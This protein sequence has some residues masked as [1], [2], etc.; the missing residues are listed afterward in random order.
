LETSDH[1]GIFEVIQ[2]GKSCSQIGLRRVVDFE[3][4]ALEVPEEVS[5]AQSVGTRWI[6]M[7]SLLRS[8]WCRGCLLPDVGVDL[9]SVSWLLACTWDGSGELLLLPDGSGGIGVFT[10]L[11][12]IIYFSILRR[13][14][15]R[16]DQDLAI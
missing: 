1:W 2:S 9:S 16:D 7:A 5:R 6:I 13:Y 11:T 8:G 14:I 15:R 3:S 10:L 12:L 4:I